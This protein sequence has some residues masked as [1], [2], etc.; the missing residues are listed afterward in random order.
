M[1]YTNVAS[2]EIETTKS[3]NLAVVNDLATTCREELVLSNRER[4]FKTIRRMLASMGVVMMACEMQSLA[5]YA[6]WESAIRYRE[7]DG[8]QFFTYCFFF[9]KAEVRR[10]LQLEND[11]RRELEGNET[12]TLGADD[13]ESLSPLES[14]ACDK[15]SADK[16]VELNQV[17]RVVFE[18]PGVLSDVEQSLMRGIYVDDKSVDEVADEMEYSRG[19]AYAIRKSAEGKIRN[20]LHE[21]HEC[22]HS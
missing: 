16:V 2:Q 15:P 4:A 11:S 17:R 1:K 12:V 9:L 7:V 18:T 13:G 14:L 20:Y 10:T 5:D 19:H 8:A 6:L 22:I 21:H 3:P